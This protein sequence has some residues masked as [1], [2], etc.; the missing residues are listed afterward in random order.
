MTPTPERE[1]RPGGRGAAESRGERNRGQFTP[2]PEDPEYAD[3]VGDAD[4]YESDP[5]TADHFAA[6]CLAAE[7][8]ELAE[9]ES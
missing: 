7:R 1:R 9:V 4:G 8:G 6:I 5:L 2:P 3:H